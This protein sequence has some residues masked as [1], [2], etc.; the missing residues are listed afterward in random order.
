MITAHAPMGVTASGMNRSFKTLNHP[1]PRFA[2]HIQTC[3]TGYPN[4]DATK[5]LS[6]LQVERTEENTE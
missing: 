5:G 2:Q 3:N 4:V 1:P 6:Y